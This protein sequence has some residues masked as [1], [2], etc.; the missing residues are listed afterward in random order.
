LGLYRPPTLLWP[1]RTAVGPSTHLFQIINDG[2]AIPETHADACGAYPHTKFPSERIITAAEKSKT[3]KRGV[4]HT[5]AL[6]FINNVSTNYVDF[7]NVNLS[8]LCCEH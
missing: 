5:G 6:R 7:E 4:L 2:T 1:F 3:A 8:Y